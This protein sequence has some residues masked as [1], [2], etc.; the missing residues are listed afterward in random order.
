VLVRRTTSNAPLRLREEA[1]ALRRSRPLFC[2][3]TRKL[4]GSISRIHNRRLRPASHAG[5]AP[6]PPPAY[7]GPPR[8]SSPTRRSP[9]TLCGPATV[10]IPT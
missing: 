9:D 3:P 7:E 1:M 10:V 5:R 8:T 4:L 6:P 2:M